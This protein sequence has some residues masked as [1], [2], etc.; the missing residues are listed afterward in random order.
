[1]D[2]SNDL[3]AKIDSGELSVKVVEVLKKYKNAFE[4]GMD[5]NA[6]LSNQTSAPGKVD[7]LRYTWHLYHLHLNISILQI[8]LLSS[9]VPTTHDT[10]P[11]IG[12]AHHISDTSA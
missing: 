8:F 5:M 12:N 2:Y 1:M 10:I 6:F 3:Q 7:F 11:V 9:I 4:E